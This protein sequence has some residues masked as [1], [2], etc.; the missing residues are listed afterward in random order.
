VHFVPSS[1]SAMESAY[2]HNS[3]LNLIDLFSGLAPI[4]PE[5]NCSSER[6][7]DFECVLL[8]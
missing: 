1:V 8:F 5:S 2:L 7:V 4:N 6:S 3:D